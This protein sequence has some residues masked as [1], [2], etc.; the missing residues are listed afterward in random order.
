MVAA[1]FLIDDALAKRP[2][3]SFA[4]GVNG[5]E[6]HFGHWRCLSLIEVDPGRLGREPD[7]G[8]RRLG[9]PPFTRDRERRCSTEPAGV[10]LASHASTMHADRRWCT[11]CSF[12]AAEANPAAMGMG[13]RAMSK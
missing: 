11:S 6:G 9:C 7:K 4:V 13:V 2:P 8:L 1:E 12:R 3:A 5:S 10:K